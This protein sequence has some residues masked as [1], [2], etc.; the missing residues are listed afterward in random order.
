ML[1]LD[2]LPEF[3]RAVLEVLREPLESR[4]I[5]ISRAARQA[6]F[7]AAFQLVAAMNP[8]PCGYLGHYSQRCRCTPDQIARYRG[9]ISGPLMDRIDMQ[10]EVP[11]VPQLELVKAAAGE[12]TTT[13]R[14]RVEK[15]AERQRQ[16]Q[17]RLNA[18]LD[19]A[20]IDRHC[21]PDAA[22]AQLLAQAIQKM[23]LSARAYHRILKLARTIADLAGSEALRS[24]HVAE[25]I[26]YRR[27]DR[28]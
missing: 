25:A 13:V 9:R 10:L 1:F 23:G 22:G 12:P 24:P 5:T 11:A 15:A 16:R 21:A 20:E 7:P 14:A 19:V 8:C 2:E 6:D 4:R 17:G 3:D 28:A 26:Q 27:M 18:L